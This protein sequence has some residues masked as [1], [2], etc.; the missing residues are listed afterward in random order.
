MSFV[1]VSIGMLGMITEITF[2]IEPK[3]YLREVLSLR[4]FE[5]CSLNFEE[6]MRGGD[7]AKMWIELFTG[8]CGLFVSNKTRETSPRDN[9]NWT[10]KNIEV[11]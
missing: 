10:V 4:S 6:L 11:S 9:P 5:D 7:H 2:E 3:Y 8:K 1:Q